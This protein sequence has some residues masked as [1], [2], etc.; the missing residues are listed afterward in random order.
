MQNIYAFDVGDYGKLGLLR[1][2]MVRELNVGV[3]WWKTEL[4]SPGQDGKHLSY[5]QKR[6][7]RECDPVLR[8]AMCRC[9]SAGPRSIQALESLFPEGTP[10]FGDVIPADAKRRLLWF[11]EAMTRVRQADVVFCDPDNGVSF[12]HQTRSQ[13]HVSLS[14]L[15]KLYRAGH[16]LAVYHHLNRTSSHAEQ[17]A[18]GAQHLSDLVADG[19]PVWTAHFRRGTSR[20]YFLLPQPRHLDAV[21]SALELLS[22][23]PWSRRG[24]FVV[25]IVAGSQE[26]ATYV[27]RESE[28]LTPAT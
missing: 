21:R 25:T 13:R 14:E 8:D 1:H 2:L 5:L 27:R 26:E 16:T 4:G 3:I 17:I 7:Y 28:L 18:A 10:F 11:D 22:K 20:V 15:Q 6:A 24:H 23:S 19:N 9:V 12:V